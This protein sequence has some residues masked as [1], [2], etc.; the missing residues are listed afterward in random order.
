MNT[1][2]IHCLNSA[3]TWSSSATRFCFFLFAL[4]VLL[5]AYCFL[6][7]TCLPF[8]YSPPPLPPKNDGRD[9]HCILCKTGAIY[10]L[11]VVERLWFVCFL[12]LDFSF[13][14]FAVLRLAVCTKVLFSI[15]V[16]NGAQWHL[17]DKETK[18]KK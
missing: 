10:M 7:F 5:L 1:K 2:N 16:E 3:V 18:S 6:R 14:R 4:C 9:I 12:L 15:S 8:T 13:L 17:S 11:T